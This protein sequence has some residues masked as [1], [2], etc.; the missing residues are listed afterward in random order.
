MVEYCLVTPYG[1]GELG[2]YWI[3]QWLFDSSPP[4]RYMNQCRG[5]VIFKW[6]PHSE[7]SSAKCP[8]F[9]S[10]PNVDA[11]KYCSQITTFPQV[12]LF[13][14]Q[15]IWLQIAKCGE[16]W[17]IWATSMVTQRALLEEIPIYQKAINILIILNFGAGFSLSTNSPHLLRPQHVSNSL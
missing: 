2:K 6:I 7:I 1:V 10:G 17:P 14:I 4:I 3:R 8:L 13:H 5:R 16:V 11:H 15:N 9:A 12:I